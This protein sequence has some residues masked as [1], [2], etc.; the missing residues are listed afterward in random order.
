L[1]EALE[2]WDREIFQAINSGMANPFFDW[3]MPLLR[4]AYIWAPLYVFFAVFAVRNFPPKGFYIIIFGLLAFMLSDQISADIL[5]PLVQRDRPCNDIIMAQYVRSLIPCGTGKSFPS[6]H[7]TNHFALA[8]FIISISPLR[9]R[10]IVPFLLVWATGVAFAQVYVGV[11]FP[12]DVIGGAILG[13]LIG[14]FIGFICKRALNLNLDRDDV[15]EE[16]IEQ[17]EEPLE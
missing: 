15:E 1:N 10:W 9:M 16:V 8:V 6:S 3:L 17:E 11:H 5:K 13:G 12:L 4:N 14:F 2:L 7:A